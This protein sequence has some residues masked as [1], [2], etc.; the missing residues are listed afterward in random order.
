MSITRIPSTDQHLPPGAVIVTVCSGSSYDTLYTQRPQT[1]ADPTRCIAVYSTDY[2]TLPAILAALQNPAARDGDSPALR[3]LTADIIAVSAEN[4]ECVAFNFECCSEAGSHGFSQCHSAAVAMV[5]PSTAK[6]PPQTPAPKKGMFA[7][8]IGVFESAPSTPPSCDRE[9]VFDARDGIMRTVAHAL[10]RGFMVI[11]GDFSLKALIADWDASLLGPLPFEQVGETS[12]TVRLRFDRERLMQCPSAQ[13]QCVGQ[14]CT[15]NFAGVH[16]LGGTIQYAVKHD[17]AA[18][19]AYTLQVL[20]VAEMPED[21]SGPRVEVGAYSG[22]CGHVMLTYR[23]GG[24]LLVSATHWIELTN[25]NANEAQVAQVLLQ[26]QGQVAVDEFN[27]QLANCKSAEERSA[28]SGSSAVRLVQ[29]SPACA[30]L[31]YKSN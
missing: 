19:D 8:L 7:S 27:A 12:G 10:E 24:V 11:F 25:V 4:P 17:R 3:A 28:F 21:Y 6:K 9:E 2:K 14:L 20:T 15:D 29:R 16:A 22:S 5:T 1:S 30:P 31:K 23:S 13:L 26:Q 18:T